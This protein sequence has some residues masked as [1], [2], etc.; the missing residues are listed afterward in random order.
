MSSG[1]SRTLLQCCL[2]VLA[3]AGL[4]ALAES[5][6]VGTRLEIRLEQPISSY[7][8]QKGT[9]I[10]GVLVAP[11]TERGEMLLP[12]GTTVE[13][14]VV[15]VR[16][17]GLGVVHETARI[18]LQFDRVVLADG[19][20]VPLQC[21]IVEVENARESVDAQGRIQ[22][23]RS[24]ATLSNRAS[25]L[26]GSLAFGDPIAAIFTTAASASV[27]RFS[28]PEISLPAGAELIA[29]LTAP[30]VLSKM[31][32]ILVPTDCHHACG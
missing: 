22:G 9:R 5:V 7:V 11:L 13:G 18:Q 32:P 19:E 3:F 12:L 2:A 14:S 17:V 27:L 21:K 30:I 6:S 20:S 8:T 24:T 31:D 10:S 25:G 16:K 4:N 29:E 26:V 1:C 23:I 28:E 15:A